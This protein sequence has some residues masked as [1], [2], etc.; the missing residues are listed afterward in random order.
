MPIGQPFA[1]QKWG[2]WLRRLAT[3]FEPTRIAQMIQIE[4]LRRQLCLVQ[5]QGASLPNFPFLHCERQR[6]ICKMIW[7][8]SQAFFRLASDSLLPT[9]HGWWQPQKSGTQL[10]KKVFLSRYLH[11]SVDKKGDPIETVAREVS[12]EKFPS[13]C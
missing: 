7:G 4:L 11:Y 1:M 13:F 5:T 9:M 10:K 8:V 12:I 2:V 3:D 6:G